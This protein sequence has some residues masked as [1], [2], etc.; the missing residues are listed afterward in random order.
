MKRKTLYL[1]EE[2]QKAIDEIK[3]DCKAPSPTFAR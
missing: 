2:Q 3:T 1:G